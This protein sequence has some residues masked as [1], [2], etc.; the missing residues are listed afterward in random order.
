MVRRSETAALLAGVTIGALGLTGC[1]SWEPVSASH[2]ASH[3]GESVRFV[4]GSSFVKM[5]DARVVDE[6]IVGTTAAGT[7][8]VDIRTIHHLEASEYDS[9]LTRNVII[10]VTLGSVLSAGIVG[11]VAVIGST[12]GKARPG[13][14]PI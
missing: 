13:F 4:A 10:Y 12:L 9:K 11:V 5:D 14:P 6:S 8:R 2:L 1:Y 7:A 3:P